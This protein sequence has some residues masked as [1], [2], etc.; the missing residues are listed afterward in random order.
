MAAASD[1]PLNAPADAA[2]VFTPPVMPDGY[3]LASG[4][5]IAVMVIVPIL[6]AVW[7]YKR[8]GSSGRALTAGMVTFGVSQLL[9]RLPLVQVVQYLLRD[10]LQS[11]TTALWLWLAVAAVSAGLFEET[12]RWYA[13]RKPLADAREWKEAV[14]LGVGHGGLESAFLVAGLSVLGTVQAL[15]FSRLDPSKLADRPPEQMTQ[16]VA[17]AEKLSAMEAW[18]PLLAAW[19]RLAALPLH[20]LL[21]VMVLQVFV[22]GSRAWLWAAIAL[23]GAVNFVAV[24]MVKSVSAVWVEIALTVVAAGCVWGIVRLRPATPTTRP[25]PG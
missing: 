2:P 14:G 19:E 3:F 6:L 15:A 22:R 17:A 18:H 23:H 10:T 16:I 20:I 11:S 9:L 8:L 5:S 4:V 21:S 13:F 25:S 1:I 7:A 24:A 12:A